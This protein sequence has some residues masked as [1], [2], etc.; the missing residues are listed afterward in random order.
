MRG[1]LTGGLLCALAFPALAAEKPKA[2]VAPPPVLQPAPPLPPMIMAPRETSEEAM[3]APPAVIAV[4][5]SGAGQKVWSGTLRVG[6]RGNANFNMNT[7]EAPERCATQAVPSAAYRSQGSN[8]RLSI[9][10]YSGGDGGREDQFSVNVGWQRPGD[11]CDG[12]GSISNGI[13]RSVMLVPGASTLLKG[14]GGL[15]VKLTRAK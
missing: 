11:P 10:L 13:D 1:F 14:D 5:V 3:L 6:R 12:G 15:T 9:A 2:A 7:S 8:F 4:E